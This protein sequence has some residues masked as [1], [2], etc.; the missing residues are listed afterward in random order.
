MKGMRRHHCLTVQLGGA[1][2]PFNKRD[3]GGCWTSFV[4]AITKDARKKGFKSM[5]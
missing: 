5:N 1:D 4:P 3:L 2:I